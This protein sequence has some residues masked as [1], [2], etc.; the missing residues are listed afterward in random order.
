MT[1]DNA[2]FVFRKYENKLISQILSQMRKTKTMENLIVCTENTCAQLSTSTA[3]V[4]VGHVFCYKINILQ[5]Y[6]DIIIIS[7]KTW[8][9]FYSINCTK[10]T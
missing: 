3:I 2:M 5:K 1:G 7:A 4:S 10:K 8:S 9:R 6:M